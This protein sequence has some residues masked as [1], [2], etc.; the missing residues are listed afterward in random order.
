[1]RWAAVEAMY[2]ISIKT[3]SVEIH[4]RGWIGWGGGAG[5]HLKH[6]HYLHNQYTDCVPNLSEKSNFMIPGY[7]L[8]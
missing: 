3:Q 2:S 5:S 8:Q 1:M 4:S 7:L 6:F